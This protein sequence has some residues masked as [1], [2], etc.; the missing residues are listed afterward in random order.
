VNGT[1]A[2]I[3]VRDYGPGIAPDFQRKV[4]TKFSQSDSSDA[5]SK[6]GSG[7]GLAI[8]KALIE[9]M[10]GHISFRTSTN[11]GTSFFI[12][13]PLRTLGAATDDAERTT[14]VL[15]VSLP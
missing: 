6:G 3:E 4:F 7:L 2:L 13:L 15:P 9:R 5:R 1:R 12:D 11:E 10:S 8:S 14:I